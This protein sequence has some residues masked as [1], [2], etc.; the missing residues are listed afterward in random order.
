[1]QLASEYRPTAISLDVFLPDM[2]GWAVLARLKHNVNTRHIPVQML[3]VDEERHSSLERG[4]FGFL[5]KPGT[6]ES[7]GEALERI[8]RYTLDRKKRMLVIEDDKRESQ[9]IV[10]LIRDDD[11][12]I[13]TAETGTEALTKL[14]ESR[15]DCVVLDLRLPD[16]TGF[17]L[18]GR[19]HADRRARCADHRF[20]RARAQRRRIASYGA[21]RR[22]SSSRASES[23]E[24][25]LTGRRCSCIAR[26]RRWRR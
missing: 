21:R 20:H 25:L 17:D 4:A 26:C 7:I 18:L 8:R 16:M 9:S 24:R 6:T 2:L 13:D 1:M 11:L 19:S 14:A 3:T 15:Y 10:E 5:A 23:P 12:E 22:A